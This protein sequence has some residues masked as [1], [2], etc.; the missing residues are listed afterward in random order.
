MLF[1]YLERQNEGH[2]ENEDRPQVNLLTDEELHQRTQ[3]IR[4]EWV[5]M[6]MNP[7]ARARLER[8]GRGEG[9]NRLFEDLRRGRRR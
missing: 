3:E 8:I 1:W 7:Q 4:L 5:R 2:P 6:S 9:H